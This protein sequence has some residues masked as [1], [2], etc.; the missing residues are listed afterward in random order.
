[1]LIHCKAG[2]HR[3]GIMAAIYRME[4]NGWTREEALHEL[5]SHGFGYFLANTSNPYIEQYVMPYQRR[6]RAGN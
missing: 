4:Y 5:R 2:L 6:S 3:T 1:V